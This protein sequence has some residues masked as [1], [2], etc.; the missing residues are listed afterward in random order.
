MFFLSLTTKKNL[1][2]R[3]LFIGKILLFKVLLF[4]GVNAYSSDTL[5]INRGQQ[6]TFFAPLGGGKYNKHQWIL[7][8][9]TLNSYGMY[10]SSF[11]KGIGFDAETGAY[12]YNYVQVRI[13]N[14]PI[15]FKFKRSS[16]NELIYEQNLPLFYSNNFYDVI[17]G[18]NYFPFSNSLVWDGN[19]DLLIE[20]CNEINIP[21]GN[22][23][24]MNSY[25]TR[26]SD[27]LEIISGDRINPV[28]TK[29]KDTYYYDGVHNMHLLW[30]SVKVPPRADFEMD[31]SISCDSV[32]SFL[33]NTTGLTSS[34]LW[35]FGDGD[36]AT[37]QNP[38][39]AYKNSGTYKV[40]L[41]VWNKYGVDSISK[42]IEYDRNF[43][44]KSACQTIPSTSIQTTGI[45]HTRIGA[46]Y[47]ESSSSQV[48]GNENFEC[49]I[50][51]G[52]AGSKT[53]I[54]LQFFQSG[55]HYVKVW[56]D[57]ND[58]GVF[59]NGS[60]TI[61]AEETSGFYSDSLY[62]PGNS[63]LHK[64]LRIR[65]ASAL[66]PITGACS[67]IFEGQYEDYSLLLDTNRLTPTPIPK[68]KS[69]SRCNGLVSFHHQSEGLYKILQW[70]FGDGSSSSNEQPNHQYSSGGT[71]WVK[72]S[73]TTAV[74]MSVSDS[75]QITVDSLF[76]MPKM[77]CV[78]N[79]A[80]LANTEGISSVK[81]TSLINGQSVELF[82]HYSIVEKT[83]Y[84]DFT[85]NNRVKIKEGQMLHLLVQGTQASMNYL[86]Y[87]DINND[88]VFSTNEQFGFDQNK[89]QSSLSFNY[90]NMPLH[91]PLRMRIGA[92]DINQGAAICNTSNAGEW[93]DYTI[94]FEPKGKYLPDTVKPEAAIKASPHYYC[95]NTVTFE[96]SSSS[97][98]N[99]RVWIFD[100]GTS[101]T[102]T[103]VTHKF[104]STGD[105]KVQ[106]VVSNNVGTDTLSKIVTVD[107]DTC[108][109]TTFKQGT[110]IDMSGCK[111]GKIAMP[112]GM[113][114]LS[115][116]KFMQIR[117]HVPDSHELTLDVVKANNSIVTQKD[118]YLKVHDGPHAGA[119]RL[120]T[121][122]SFIGPTHSFRP[123]NGKDLTL[124]V[125]WMLA[126][127]AIGSFDIRYRC[128]SFKKAKPIKNPNDFVNESAAANSLI[129]TFPNPINK[130]EQQSVTI[131][132]R[133]ETIHSI[134]VYSYQGN[135]IF[136]EQV[137]KHIHSIDVSAFKP[138][139]YL[140]H[141]NTPAS[142]VVKRLVV[143]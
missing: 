142:A 55:K 96:D 39:H 83:G 42:T 30:D 17:K 66:K 101:D 32:F 37:S 62:I 135:E 90:L 129:E 122:T 109:T 117:L 136:T 138:G 54:E 50:I 61:L 21:S 70:H 35:K 100:D 134:T 23:A 28:C 36:S 12:D 43:R 33:D 56:L 53:P 85:C 140:V 48:G 115:G 82:N 139:V 11:I 103:L 128:L 76:A 98:V 69:K 1:I 41:T 99:S 119:P 71:Y 89:P 118:L 87:L 125:N 74:G 49:T 27:T 79:N 68:I 64:P 108:K 24:Y 14:V 123:R 143:Q 131:K 58:D 47:N 104:D 67:T 132:S 80:Q 51:R 93:E 114:D 97:N 10:D 95:T 46:V 113:F 19:S 141:V 137:N 45:K 7:R 16:S 81:F 72:L 40:T 86:G 91:T 59:D 20:F 121:Y 126:T 29:L 94:W 31:K 124:N 9:S 112:T 92:F 102:N 75:I 44:P 116:D 2:V 5:K 84:A 120:G 6:K 34:Y 60:E 73:L 77:A 18:Y 127:Q 107:L 22:V 25:V 8:K 26:L 63:L 88:G 133:S 4:C 13:K 38:S 15:N 52:T 78:P 106:L 3:L 130:Q 65:I 110:V 57:K 105:Y 111:G